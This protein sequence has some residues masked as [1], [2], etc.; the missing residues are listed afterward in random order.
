M[1]KVAAL[2]SAFELR[3]VVKAVAKEIGAAATKQDILPQIARHSRGVFE[4]SDVV[5]QAGAYRFMP[6]P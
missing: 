6:T 4:N 3:K 5:V 1:I 2:Y